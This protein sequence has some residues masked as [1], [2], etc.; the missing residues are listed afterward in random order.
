VR[1]ARSRG[2]ESG[3]VRSVES[4]VLIVFSWSLGGRVGGGSAGPILDEAP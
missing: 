3:A 4:V 1:S 2:M